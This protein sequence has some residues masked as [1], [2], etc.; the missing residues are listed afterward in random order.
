MVRLSKLVPFRFCMFPMKRVERLLRFSYWFSR[1]KP[2]FS[3]FLWVFVPEKKQENS[4][5]QKRRKSCDSIWPSILV[6]FESITSLSCQQHLVSQL[7][8]DSFF[9]ISPM[10]SSCQVLPVTLV[11]DIESLIN[12]HES[13]QS[14]RFHC[15]A[16]GCNHRYRT[17]FAWHGIDR[18]RFLFDEGNPWSVNDVVRHR[19]GV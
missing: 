9:F 15:F 12:D 2:N 14:L 18:Y 8:N 11:I 19:R 5:K 13:T 3:I 16:T 4:R 6:H 10:W 7:K 17:H 1:E